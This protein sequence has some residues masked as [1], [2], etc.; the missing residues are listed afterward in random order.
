MTGLSQTIQYRIK[1]VCRGRRWLD[2]EEIK[3]MDPRSILIKENYSVIIVVSMVTLQL[4]VGELITIIALENYLRK[5]KH[6]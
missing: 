6:I 1:A 3:I 2:V 5:I 4:N